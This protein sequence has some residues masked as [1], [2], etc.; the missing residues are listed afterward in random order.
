MKASF[1]PGSAIDKAINILALIPVI[2]WVLYPMTTHAANSVQHSGDQALIFEVKNLQLSSD[3][4]GTSENID[5]NIQFTGP[6]MTYA[7]L[8]SVS[9]DQEAKQAY[10]EQLRNYLAQRG[11]PF[12]QCVDLL[13][14]LPTADKILSLANAESGL[15]THAP[16]GKYNYWGVGGGG[17]WKMGNSV[18]EG[19]QSMDNFLNAYPKNSAVKYKDMTIERM[20]GLYKQPA[21]IHWVRNNYVVLND[22]QALRAQAREIAQAKVNAVHTAA[23]SAELANK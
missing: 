11:S 10:K 2:V 21:A 15:G 23:V 3:N 1:I 20:N 17:L 8:V 12:V 14:E 19:I 16:W 9:I 13:A 4:S 22:L 7:D 5:Q 18:C 6:A